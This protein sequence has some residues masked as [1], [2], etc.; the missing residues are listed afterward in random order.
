MALAGSDAQLR[1]FADYFALNTI[2]RDPNSVAAAITAAFGGQAAGAVQLFLDSRLEARIEEFSDGEL[3]TFANRLGVQVHGA[4]RNAVV[5]ALT[6]SLGDRLGALLQLYRRWQP[7]DGFSDKE[8]VEFAHTTNPNIPSNDLAAATAAIRSQF[9]GQSRA[10]LS[11]YRQVANLKPLETL[12]DNALVRFLS[13]TVRRANLTLYGT[14]YGL[15]VF[16]FV[17]IGFIWNLWSKTADAHRNIESITKEQKEVAERIERQS[18][19]LQDTQSAANRLFSMMQENVHTILEKEEKE[20]KKWEDRATNLE[21]RVEQ[22]RHRLLD[23]AQSSSLMLEIAMLMSPPGQSWSAERANVMR[24]LDYAQQVVAAQTAIHD[25]HAP[26][27]I[28]FLE[29]LLHLVDHVRE[30][31]EHLDPADAYER[32]VRELCSLI[33]NEI[34]SLRD[35]V[36]HFTASAPPKSSGAETTHDMY[37]EIE[38]LPLDKSSPSERFNAVADAYLDFAEGATRLFEYYFTPTHDTSYLMMAIGPLQH[39]A[40]SSRRLRWQALNVLGT[41]YDSLADALSQKGD[42]AKFNEYIAKSRQ[43]W[44]EADDTDNS[45]DRGLLVAQNRADSEYKEAVFNLRKTDAPLERTVRLQNARLH[46]LTAKRQIDHVTDGL[47]PPILAFITSAEV[48]GTI[49][50]LCRQGS[51]VDGKVPDE[52]RDTAIEDIL[53]TY[54]K[55]PA[56]HVSAEAWKR[57]FSSIQEKLHRSSA[58]LSRS[59]ISRAK[60]FDQLP[61]LRFIA[62]FPSRTPSQERMNAMTKAAGFVNP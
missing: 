56:E 25:G 26:T 52:L 32:R 37:Q 44:Q 3:N 18:L 40:N 12:V 6:A 13:V 53:I 27:G 19:A 5:Q 15:L 54:K 21:T 2:A 45:S 7:I 41:V 58:E 24:S 8:L 46:A 20:E 4:D 29:R 10:I 1:Q 28:L 36:H 62:N 48:D 23:R 47:K 17:A 42:E 49:L 34:Q 30:L 59:G 43:A 9:Q 61:G 57:F 38:L 31:R 11:V 55:L 60:F 39:A 22:E 51:F 16:F 33:P 14:I 50:E 35:D